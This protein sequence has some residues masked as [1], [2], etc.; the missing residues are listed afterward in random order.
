M[1][2]YKERFFDFEVTP[3]WWCVS[4]GDL[5]DDL[6]DLNEN[7]KNDFLT[8]DSDMKN[9]RELV[10][11]TLREKYHVMFGYNIKGYDLI[12]ANAIYQGFTA[13][14]VFII[15]DLI[16]NPDKV[17]FNKE[18]LRL[19]S[20]S[21]R[22]LK[23]I[24]YEDLLDDGS[25]SLKEKE[26][27]LGLD[28]METTVPFD[29]EDLT[30]EDKEDI[31]KYNKHDVYA[32]M[33]YYKEV[34]KPY[35][36]VKL[37]M[38]RK[39]NIPI[40]TCY[41]STNARLVAMALGATRQHHSDAERVDIVLP[42]KIR[43]YC[44]KNMPE[45]IIERIRLSTNSFKAK[46]FENTV[47][48]GN[49]GVHSTP[50]DVNS[51]SSEGLYVESDDEYV[52]M[53]VD[54][55]SYYPSQMIQFKLLSRNVKSYQAF[56][57][58]FDE[59]IAIK[60]KTNKTKEDE[61]ANL[62][63]KLVLN[64]TFGASG[65]KW[66]DL[67]DPYMCTS[68]CRVGQIFLTALACKL[69]NT[70]KDLKIIQLN[71]DGILCYFKRIYIEKVRECMT[72]WSEVSGIQMEEEIVEKIWQ[73]NVNNY[74]MV[75]GNGDV[76]SKGAWLNDS[77]YRTGYVMLSPQNANICARA[78]TQYLIN[79]KNPIRFLLNCN[80]L[81]DFVIICTKGPTFKG[82]VQRLSNG[83]EI[84]LF[85]CNRVIATKDE[86][87]GKLYKWKNKNGTRSYN[88]MPGIPEHCKT[89]NYALDSYDFNE[90]KKELDYKFYVEKICDLLDINWKMYTGNNLTVTH[91]FDFMKD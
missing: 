88:S 73:L 18:Y 5:P 91:M 58:V 25:G 14:Q 56:I 51:N 16:I 24:V 29:K 78:V 36:M 21:K 20:F 4:F 9:A 49:G 3:N 43:D 84:D 7:I 37:S 19:S 79:G 28:I 89:V 27:I 81:S 26:A 83:M 66:L 86:S 55:T 50:T 87:L 8:I 35:S 32:S 77:I 54:A 60:H 40:E 31:K 62:A 30:D 10:I 85:K 23:N 68:V 47:V 39:F 57:D 12:I 75:K 52:L 11:D 71:T 6:N 41:T 90:I 80:N 65:N 70:V 33:I 61:D 34:V 44:Y 2:K 67:Y 59:R 76:K 17:M 13:Q 22:K 38:G 63:D 48:F 42:E 15:S 74:L 69:Y 82:V 64:T 46:L 45:E 53:N 72:E 1:F